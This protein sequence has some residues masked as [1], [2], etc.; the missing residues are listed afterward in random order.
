M[1][2]LRVWGQDPICSST[3]F[4]S[5]LPRRKDG[6][7]RSG[8]LLV[9]DRPFLFGVASSFRRRPAHEAIV[10]YSVVSHGFHRPM[11]PVA[12]SV[13]SIK[14]SSLA[15]WSLVLGILAVV[16][17]CVGPLFAIPAVICGHLAYSRVKRSGGTLKGDGL[18]LGGLITGY[19]A[20]ALA[21]V[22]IP[23]MA[24][25]L[26]PNYVNVRETDQQTKCLN[27]LRRIDGAKQVW[28]LQNNKG[29]NSTPTMQDLTPFLK[30]NAALRC[31][32]GGTY[33]INRIGVVPTCSIP[34]HDLFNP[35]STIQEILNDTTNSSR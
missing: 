10:L 30:G 17:V 12:P 29:T 14:T 31:P 33:S 7:F 28:A 13:P 8:G 21:L 26:I 16:L 35:G 24:A 6:Q 18:A 9:G 4:W 1:L 27:N 19:I 3:G 11:E 20:L 22:L 2:F 5:T 34:S 15:I 25:I 23:M 32:A